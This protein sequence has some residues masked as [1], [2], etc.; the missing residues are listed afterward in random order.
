MNCEEAQNVLESWIVTSSVTT[1]A[2]DYSG[3]Q[4]TPGVITTTLFMIRL[5]SL[6][7]FCSTEV[8]PLKFSLFISI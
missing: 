6:T 4:A 1:E 7:T 8:V 2:C 5:S 3:V